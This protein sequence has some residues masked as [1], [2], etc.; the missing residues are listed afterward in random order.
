VAVA[1]ACAASALGAYVVVWMQRRSF[2]TFPEQVY[3]LDAVFVT[4]L[5]LGARIAVG[6]LLQRRE[7]SH[8]GTPHRVLI[9]GAGRTGRSLA[10]EL[11][12]TPGERAVG[13]LDDNTQVRRRRILGVVVAGTLDEASAAL[14]ATTPDEVVVTIPDAPPERLAHVVGA[15]EE[16]GVAC[17][18]LHR[19]T[20]PGSRALLEA[21]AR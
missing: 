16:A 12:E 7:E 19:R 1:F 11:R 17:R 21:Q 14:T 2:A 8:G 4:V 15:C 20:E 13:F 9:V 6:R 18:F 10:R 3:L 5:I